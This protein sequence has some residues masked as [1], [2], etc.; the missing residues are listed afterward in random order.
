MKKAFTLIELLVTIAILGILIAILLPAMGSVREGARRAQCANNLRQ[1]GIAWYLYL[2]DHD[3]RFPAYDDVASD[4]QCTD[5]TFGGKLGEYYMPTPASTR[6]INRYLDIYDDSSPN[7][8]LFH[9]LDD[10]KRPISGAPVP[11]PTGSLFNHYGTSYQANYE[12]IRYSDD[13]RRPLTTVTSPSDRVFL[14]RCYFINTPGHGGKGLD[15]FNTLVMVL[16][17][18]GHVAG[19]FLYDT[20]F[21]WDPNNQNHKVLEDPNGDQISFN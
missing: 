10:I 17:M 1:H 5:Y 2:D 21:G 16:F 14:E 12:I 13:D 15:P 8:E 4:T 7:V 6:P 3:E 20:D 9:C 11:S 19:P 18:D